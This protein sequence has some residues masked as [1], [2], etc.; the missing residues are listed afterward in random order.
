MKKRLS[1]ICLVVILLTACLASA[2]GQAPSSLDYL[3]QQLEVPASTLLEVGENVQDI[4]SELI[5]QP[6]M[7][8]Y[9]EKF[10]LREHGLVTPVKLQNPWGT[11]W[12]FGTIAA[13]E[14]SVLSMLGLTAEEYE[15]KYGKPL[16]LSE[17]HLAWFMAN[18]LP[19]LSDYPEGEYPFDESQAGEGFHTPET[20]GPVLNLGGDSMFS[21]S[22]LAAGM[23]VVDET[24]APYRSNAG[25]LSA[26]SD[27]SLPETIRFV[28][29]YELKDSNVLPSPAGRDADNQYFYRPEGTW[30]IKGELLK[31]HGVTVDYLADQSMP[32]LSMEEK[33]EILKER[34]EDADGVS[35]A[36]K[37][38]Y[39]E[40][41]IGATDLST[42]ADEALAHLVVVRCL[43]NGK[44][45]DTYDVASLDHDALARLITTDH[46]GDPYDRIVEEEAED[47]RE[48]RY[49]SFTGSDPVVYAQYT[50]DLKLSNHL[51]CIVGWDDTFPASNFG[52]ENQPPAD[53]AWIVKNSWSED[54]GTD[55]Y[56]YLSYY[57]KNIDNVECH[58]FIH[59][60]DVKNIDRLNLLQYDIM[61]VNYVSSTL[62]DAPVYAA[63]VF[64]IE[65]DSV[66]Q[67][68]S[69]MTGDMNAL[70]TASIYRLN[71]GATSPT[72][73]L[74]LETVSQT[75]TYAGYHR[76]SLPENLALNAGDTIA[77]TVLERVPGA[78]DAKYA[79]VNT[80]SLNE[81]GMAYYN[82]HH[83]GKSEDRVMRY[84]VG[85]VNRGES[86]LRLPGEDW[87]DWADVLEY[88][89]GKGSCACIAYDNLP[90]KG[91][92]YPMEEVLGAHKLDDQMD[93]P[94]GA[95]AICLDCGYVLK[96]YLN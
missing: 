54:W 78:N 24:L 60:D 87:M 77:I 6:G 58:D 70:V 13:C 73:G 7:H 34:I 16:D 25:D 93:I 62:F 33:R 15:A 69:T 43:V 56:F 5:F 81:K 47:A 22:T 48:K 50:Y 96:S 71:E 31:G 91:Y 32:E 92:A 14:S 41:R 45:E 51:V 12:S 83:V 84:S 90:V 61:P 38:A 52:E 44:P 57:D 42:L 49:M 94:D 53:G 80:S 20:A 59:P 11:C 95:A 85:V 74:M 36:D 35:E 8:A 76:I 10:D 39:V 26:T 67:Y 65:E 37:D 30:A 23:G 2:E 75:F 66:L 68:V 63:N 28:Q 89:G 88:I 82:D 64:S 55:G 17:R 86:F 79:L 19:E 72:D 1:V 29:K 18:A 4:Y 46:F 40:A 21:T 9:P 27:W 3:A